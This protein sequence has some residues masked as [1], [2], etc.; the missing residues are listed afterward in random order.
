MMSLDWWNNIIVMDWSV[1]W[2]Q[3]LLDYNAELNLSYIITHYYI[4][5]YG[6]LYFV[7][8]FRNILH[9][10]IHVTNLCGFP[11]GIGPHESGCL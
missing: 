11:N 6:L 9:C 2:R 4:K 3:S 8:F 7:S 1:G 5:E 10:T